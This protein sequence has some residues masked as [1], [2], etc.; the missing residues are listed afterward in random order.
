[1]RREMFGLAISLMVLAASPALA[2]EGNVFIGIGGN[3]AGEQFDETGGFDVDDSRTL[4]AQLGYRVNDYLAF[5][6]KYERIDEFDLSATDDFGLGLGSVD[7]EGD[8]EGFIGGVNAKIFPL[9]SGRIRP[10][11]M[12]GLGY[13]KLDIDLEANFAGFQLASASEDEKAAVLQ[14]GLG[15]D[16]QLTDNWFVELE[17]SYKFPQSDL[18]D[19][20]F[21]VIGGSVQFRF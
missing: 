8:A 6:L 2:E 18:E 3:F 1:M 10:Y 20:K 12:A 9:Q 4:T 15:V 16:L 17:G 19:F 14:A 13:M 7:F 5:E 21:F 11:I